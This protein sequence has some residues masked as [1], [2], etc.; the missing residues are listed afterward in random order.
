MED[1]PKMLK[2]ELKRLRKVLRRERRR[3]NHGDDGWRGGGGGV[4]LG[5]GG[6]TSF[7]RNTPISL[8]SCSV[9]GEDRS[10]YGDDDEEEESEVVKGTSSSKKLNPGTGK[11]ESAGR[12][13]ALNKSIRAKMRQLMGIE[14]KDPLPD[15]DVPGFDERD[16]T[17]PLM[18]PNWRVSITNGFNK[19]ILDQVVNEVI[20]EAWA[21]LHQPERRLPRT[22]IPEAD[23]DKGV[24]LKA[25]KTTF[26]NFGK[27]FNSETDPS[28]KD[29]VE[30]DTKR[31]RRWARKDLKQKRRLKA[32]SDPDYTSHTYPNLLRIDYMSSEYSSE[33]EG[34]GGEKRMEEGLWDLI[35]GKEKKSTTTTGGGEGAGGEEAEGSGTGG[36]TGTKGGKGKGRGRGK[37]G[38]EKK[39]LEVRTPRWRSED[40]NAVYT[41]LDRISACQLKVSKGK[42]HN[43][44]SHTRF[45]LNPL[46]DLPPPP[47]AVQRWEFDPGWLATEGG[48][49]KEARERMAGGLE[50]GGTEGGGFELG[51]EQGEE[52]LGFE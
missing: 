29:H 3:G 16:G 2:D 24:V 13:L 33:G 18:R 35:A 8:G 40:L 41:D 4:M 6:E 21:S 43:I 25:A 47:T 52:T 46:R 27:K 31:R 38:D 10:L 45:K 28:K 34:E 23:L 19:K 42:I 48:P 36:A 20:E 12:K 30:R 37:I 49:N 39:V 11:K 44:P 32:A 15:P 51:G 1:D 26:I 14:D 7:R 9:L 22:D 5:G 50:V 17:T